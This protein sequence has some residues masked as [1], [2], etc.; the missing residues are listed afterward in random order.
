MQD[1]TFGDPE[2][3]LAPLRH[4]SRRRR[5]LFAGIAV[6]LGAIVPLALLETALRLCPPSWLEQRMRE[7]AAGRSDESGSDESWPV[8]VE[9]RAFRQFVPGSRFTVR[10]DEYRHAATID[11]LGGR[12][13]PHSASA[14]ELVPFLGDSFTFG[15]GV[16][17]TETFVSLI[18]AETLRS[19]PSGEPPRLLNLGMTGTALHNQLDTLELRHRELGSPGFYVFTL[20]L[21]NDLTNIRRHHDRSALDG[22]SRGASRSRRWLWQANAFVSRHPALRRLYA[23]QFLRQKLL[24]VVHRQ[25]GGFLDPLFLAMRQDLDDL[26]G[27]LVFFRKELTR[28]AEVSDRLGFEYV[29]ILIPDVHQLDASRLAGKARSL[30]LEPEELEPQRISRAVSR[31]LSDFGVRHFD[32]GPCLSEG[33]IGGLYYNRDTH[34]TAAGHALAARCILESGLLQ[35]LTTPQSAPRSLG[36]LADSPS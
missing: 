4:A 28:L 30:G 17:D 20:F 22:S 8:V 15:V 36:S 7:L 23:P 33:S 1:S 13:T 11:E 25:A 14:R 2:A 32:L 19:L 31:T 29:F 3:P 34:L 9:G 6:V 16:D 35:P 18:A 24:T 21:G 27:A 26:D 10:H 12:R 5:A